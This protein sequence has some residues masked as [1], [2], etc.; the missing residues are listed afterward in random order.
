MIKSH[1]RS[2][3]L[4]FTPKVQTMKIPVTSV[5]LG[6]TTSHT[7][8]SFDR[9][10]RRQDRPRF[11]ERDTR[12]NRKAVEEYGNRKDIEEGLGITHPI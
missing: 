10:N 2:K 8:R 7:L 4:K 3:Q 1:P 6:P 5:K 9:G 12:Q 11:R